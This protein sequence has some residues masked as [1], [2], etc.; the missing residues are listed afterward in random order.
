[1]QVILLRRAEKLAE[2]FQVPSSGQ[3]T[4]KRRSSATSDTFALAMYRPDDSV[5]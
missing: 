3:Y 4:T 5:G 1:M 2:S